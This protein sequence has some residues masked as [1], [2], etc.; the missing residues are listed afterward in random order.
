M[1]PSSIKKYLIDKDSVLADIIPKTE[2]P[3]I[4]SSKNVFNDLLSCIIEQQIHYRSSRNIFKNLLKKS[5]LKEVTLSNFEIFEEKALSGIK[6]SSKK[7]EAIHEL[8]SFFQKT[9]VDWFELSDTEVTETLSSIKGIG[10]WSIHMIL[11]YTLERENIFPHA[12][13]HLKK[14]M[15]Q[16]YEID[17]KVKRN[18]LEIANSWSPYTSTAIKY[19]LAYKDTLNKKEA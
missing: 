12:D 19:L 5:D 15:M 1:Q 3:H 4:S 11:L 18:M 10:E 14:L 13:F 8:V 9:S 17:S 7:A 6:I 16:L 2:L